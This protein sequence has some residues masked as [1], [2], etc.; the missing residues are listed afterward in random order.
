MTL[1]QAVCTE[2]P[3][4]C[5][6]LSSL[7]PTVA[8]SGRNINFDREGLWLNVKDT[9]C[10]P[11]SDTHDTHPNCSAR[12]L[13]LVDIEWEKLQ[14]R[15]C[16]NKAFTNA[17]WRCARQEHMLMNLA[18]ARETARVFFFFLRGGYK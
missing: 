1:L 12:V 16:C 14:S 9:P 5:L 11:S 18:V 7:P 13:L 15:L 17:E 2:Q 8:A 4:Y 10:H 6:Y 3:Q